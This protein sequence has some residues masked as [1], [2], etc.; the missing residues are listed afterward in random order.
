MQIS[1]CTRS[2]Q[3]FVFI[4]DVETPTFRKHSSSFF[5]QLRLD[6]LYSELA[7]ASFFNRTFS[8]SPYPSRRCASASVSELRDRIFI[9]YSFFQSSSVFAVFYPNRALTWIFHSSHCFILNYSISK[10]QRKKSGRWRSK[11]KRTFSILPVGCVSLNWSSRRFDSVR[12]L[13]IQGSDIN[14]F[15]STLDEEQTPDS[16]NGSIDR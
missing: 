7:D 13:R 12:L 11:T 5:N 8:A 4:N 3:D 6:L 10:A 9:L 1:P 16:A 2:S 14:L 15:L